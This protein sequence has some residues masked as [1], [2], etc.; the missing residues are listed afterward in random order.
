MPRLTSIAADC[1]AK[2][3]L[4]TA[5]SLE[6]FD[7]SL[8]PELQRLEWIATDEEQHHHQENAG[9]DADP[10]QLPSVEADNV[11]FLQYT[12]G[13]TS[14]PKGVMVSHANLLSNMELIL[15][16]N[17]VQRSAE[18]KPGRTGVFWIPAYHDMGLICGILGTVYEGGHS[19]LMT[20]TSFLQRPLRWLQAIS[21]YKAQVSGA[22]NFAYEI[23][24]RKSTARERAAL[25]LSSWRVAFCSAE[26]VRPETLEQFTEAFAPSG[27]SSHA[28]YPCYG[29][30]EAT[31]MA[32]GNHG[33]GRPVVKQIVRSALAENRWIEAGGD[34]FDSGESVIRLVGCGGELL[35]QRLAI[36]DPH[37]EQ[38]INGGSVG[39]I[40]IKGPCV[41]KGYWGR[42]EE[43]DRVFRAR[44]ACNND[45]P[46]LRSGDLGFV[47]DGQLFVTGRVKDVIIIRGRNYYPHDIERTAE[48]S[49]PALLPGAGAAFAV[50]SGSHERLHIVHEIDRHQRDADFDEVFRRIRAAVAEEHDLEVA[51]IALIRQASLPRTTSGKAQ[52]RLCRQLYLDGELKTLAQ[53][54]ITSPTSNNNGNGAANGRAI[55]IQR[56]RAARPAIAPL[57]RHGRPLDENELRRLAEQI[58]AWLL[59]WLVD[60]AG[61]PADDVS[62]DRPFVE[63]GLD[64]LK[65]VELSQELE[66]W[67]GVQ[68]S[69][70]I[71][72][73]Y[74]TPEALAEYLA[75][76][77]GGVK[78]DGGDVP[79][80]L[81]KRNTRDFVQLLSEVEA[82]GDDEL[83][84]ELNN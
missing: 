55:G 54:E 22:P 48:A 38:R 44:L 56:P 11:C 41:A 71:A 39:E 24:V 18:E 26:P 21:K 10:R 59:Q 64:S 3:A 80:D 29:L 8:S 83:K 17:G 49:H 47:A 46:Y 19:V 13:S 5:A 7:L 34:S 37:T 28:F 57:A 27:F 60:R 72:W 30:A 77:A 63:Y 68:L 36:V 76:E 62:P 9:H 53:W 51:G 1:D 58:E 25:D 42:L 84:R 74:P 35:D 12:S 52:R 79:G 45:G 6:T 78:P 65:A 82:L 70:V 2:L 40:W 50:E 31:L 69:S 67:L 66:D 32:A 16:G 4:T 73:K 61:M 33:P 23:C 75:R 20:P 14:D 43:S 15:V 81:R